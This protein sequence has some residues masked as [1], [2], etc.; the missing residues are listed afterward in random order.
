MCRKSEYLLPLSVLCYCLFTYFVW[1]P[2]VVP[3]YIK[4]YQCYQYSTKKMHSYNELCSITHTNMLFYDN[5][6][7]KLKD[8][9]RIEQLELAFRFKNNDLPVDLLPLFQPNINSYNT[10]NMEKGGLN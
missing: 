8:I 4:E 5:Q 6:I 3:D 10:R 9:I 1:L 2:S 7:L